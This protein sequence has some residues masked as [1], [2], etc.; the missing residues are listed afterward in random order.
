MFH[1]QFSILNMC[2]LYIDIYFLRNDSIFP[3]FYEII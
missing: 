2:I 1:F 3:I